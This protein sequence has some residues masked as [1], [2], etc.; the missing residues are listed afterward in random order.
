M[1]LHKV[2]ITLTKTERDALS[3]VTNRTGETVQSFCAA[4]IADA[5]LRILDPSPPAITYAEIAAENSLWIRS[6]LADSWLEG[7]DE[8]LAAKATKTMDAIRQSR[9]WPEMRCGYLP[10]HRESQS[11]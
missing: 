9:G 10:P 4:A 2:T 3:A 7:G 6:L 5:A 11:R 8:A 1:S